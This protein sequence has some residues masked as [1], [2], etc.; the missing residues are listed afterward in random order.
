MNINF[1]KC[2]EHEGTEKYLDMLFDNSLIPIIT[3]PTRITDH[4][5]TLID[6]IY[7]NLPIS[8]L[9]PG[10]LKVDI[11]DHLPVFCIVKTQVDKSTN[12]IK[13]RD[14]RKFNKQR[15]LDDIKQ[16]SWDEI[17]TPNKSL[18]KKTQDTI[19]T[20]NK[21]V[22]N[23]AP[24]KTV[25]QAK[26]KQLNKPWLTT[27]IFKSIIKKQKCIAHIFLS[28]I[29]HKI[30]EYKRYA[31]MLT[32]IKQKSKDYYQPNSQNIKIILN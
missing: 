27:G 7:T 26:Q 31:N 25:T 29:P 24:V 13:F 4:S 32:F 9:T 10:I 30:N 6:H 16:I 11:S 5:S 12:K 18:D 23:H 22:D 15:F 14:F 17:L 3:K 1:L 28:K 2:N 19:S 8:K 20:L 21:V